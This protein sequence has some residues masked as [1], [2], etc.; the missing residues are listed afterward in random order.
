MKNTDAILTSAGLGGGEVS[1]FPHST[2]TPAGRAANRAEVLRCLQRGWCVEHPPDPDDGKLILK[3]GPHDKWS[4]TG[5]E[6][7]KCGLGLPEPF[8]RADLVAAAK[9][10]EAKASNTMTTW[11]KLGWIVADRAG[12]ARTSGFGKA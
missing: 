10:S 8:G 7:A 6:M 4:P 3:H 5:C 11:R 2:T 12:W 1:N 9:V